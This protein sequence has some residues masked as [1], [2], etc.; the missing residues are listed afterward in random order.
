MCHVG[1]RDGKS[2][3]VRYAAAVS[4]VWM[5]PPADEAELFGR[6][7]RWAGSRLSEAAAAEGGEAPQALL[8]A[9]GWTGQL[10]ER[11]L[12]ATASSRAEPDF[13]E[14]GVELK[15]LPVTRLGRPCESTFVCTIPLAEIGS[16]EWRDSRVR[17]KLARVLWIP[18]EG[19]RSIP[20]GERIIGQAFLWSPS[21]ADEALLRFDWEELSGMIGRGDVDSITGHIGKCLQVRPKAANSR[22]RRWAT[23]RDGERLKALPRGF[24]LRA[25][26]TAEILKQN[27]FLP[28][29]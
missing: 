4:P 5:S 23:G 9:K 15:T 16:V 17:R 8:K 25:S 1:G 27:L 13:P 3:R 14:L 24:Y 20:I 12:G 11:L 19:E 2:C 7:S 28:G 22:A 10:M 18:V 6:A 21:A 29:R 26:Y